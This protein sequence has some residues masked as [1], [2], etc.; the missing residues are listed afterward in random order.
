MVG[1]VTGVGRGEHGVVVG[2]EFCVCVG[3]GG[4]VV[5]GSVAWRGGCMV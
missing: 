5:C 4:G 1:G 2:G 3:V